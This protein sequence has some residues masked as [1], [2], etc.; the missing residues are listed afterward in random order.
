[1]DLRLFP[2]NTVLF[3]GMKLPLHI[4]EERYKLMIRECIEEDAPFGVVLIKSGEE[5]GD[6]AVPHDMGTTARILQVEYLDDGRMNIFT[7]GERR[8]RIV[9]IN[10]TQPYL[11]GEVLPLED[12]PAKDAAYA[13]M[14]RAR[15][16]F[17]DYLKTYFSIA[18]QWVREVY[19]P[20][21][22]GN[23]ADYIA[24]RCDVPA[25]VKQ[26]WLEELDPEAR[27]RAQLEAIGEALPEMHGR[28]VAHL[29]Q[30]T[31]GFG[32]MN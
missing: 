31:T 6:G 7:H 26:Q 17:D 29:R 2:L 32:V 14:P 15:Q 11:R 22:P 20:D 16:M 5:V 12:E 1:M 30:K 3:P 28:L 27:L 24:A 21:D 18:D 9:A 10:T 23:A 8:F 13:A 19:L 25:E 4:F